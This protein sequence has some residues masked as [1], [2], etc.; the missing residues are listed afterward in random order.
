MQGLE[1]LRDRIRRSFGRVLAGPFDH[2][3]PDHLQQPGALDIARAA[4]R[5]ET[6]GQI[7][8]LSPRPLRR[9]NAEF[10]QTDRTWPQGHCWGSVRKVSGYGTNISTEYFFVLK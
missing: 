5:T 8:H 6:R 2:P 9:Q 7:L 1:S 3:G 4:R 10:V